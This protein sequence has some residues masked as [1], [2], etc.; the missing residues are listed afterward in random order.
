MQPEAILAQT[1]LV[2]P[3]L[4]LS[5]IAMQQ[6]GPMADFEHRRDR[7]IVRFSA[8]LNLQSAIDLVETIDMLHRVYFYD[9]IEIQISSIGGVST[10]LEH[11][12][13]AHERWRAASV[14]GGP[15]RRGA[16]RG[17]LRRTPARTACRRGAR[18]GSHGLRAAAGG[19]G[20]PVRGAVPRGRI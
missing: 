19:A 18:R 3:P 14:R 4:G 5:R 2:L 12:L 15:P 16:A 7:G 9:L 20:R 1:P 11:C 17:G 10:A 6:G 13:A 8:S